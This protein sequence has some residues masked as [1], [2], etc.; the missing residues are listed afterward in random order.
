[1]GKL[2]RSSTSTKYCFFSAWELQDKMASYMTRLRGTEYFFLFRFLMLYICISSCLIICAKSA[3]TPSYNTS[4][5][6]ERQMIR[7]V[8]NG[9][10][11]WKENKLLRGWEGVEIVS[12]RQR[13]QVMFLAPTMEGDWIG[14]SWSHQEK[15]PAL[16]LSSVFMVQGWSNLDLGNS[17]STLYTRGYY[18]P[19]YQV[20]CLCCVQSVS[21]LPWECAAISS[22]NTW[23]TLEPDVDSLVPG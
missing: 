19:G 12:S 21:N 14:T 16:E 9:F 15:S 7:E 8:W 13:R 11:S 4:T 2:S 3:E 23:A 20:A 22:L 17:R 5:F 10:P 18:K 1:M 6:G